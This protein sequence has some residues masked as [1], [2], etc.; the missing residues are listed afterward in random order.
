[1]CQE[2]KISIN[3][4]DAS[5]KNRHL[6]K[7]GWH[8]PGN[9]GEH[10]PCS[11]NVLGNRNSSPCFSKGIWGTGTVPQVPQKHLGNRNS[12]SSSSKLFGE[13]EQFPKFLKSF[14]GNILGN[15]GELWGTLGNSGEQARHELVTK[16]WSSV[17]SG[18]IKFPRTIF[19]WQFH[20]QKTCL[21]SFYD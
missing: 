20:T 4:I 17:Y 10:F 18:D 13:Q 5:R 3:K 11:P 16:F 19:L 7:T 8:V 12:S 21:P 9:F 6:K 15:F 14:L 1:M 2:I